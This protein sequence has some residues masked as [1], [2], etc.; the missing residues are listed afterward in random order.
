[1][2]NTFKKNEDIADYVLDGRLTEKSD[3]HN[4][5]WRQLID[6]A[7]RLGRALTEEE[8]KKFLVK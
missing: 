3:G 5:H 4:Y 1:M 7:E 2:L 6:E 8:A